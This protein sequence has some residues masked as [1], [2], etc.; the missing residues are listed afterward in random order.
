MREVRINK[1]QTAVA[2]RTDAPE[3][4]WNAWGYMNVTNGG[5]W[6]DSEHVKDWDR[7]DTPGEATSSE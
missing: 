5:G 4:A 2:V 3:D 1:D 6:C 7:L